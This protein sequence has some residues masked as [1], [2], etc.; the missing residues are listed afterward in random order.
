MRFVKNVCDMFSK[1]GIDDTLSAYKKKRLLVFNRLNS[2][3]L[4]MAI[5]W[6]VFT[7]SFKSHS[8]I[9]VVLN[10]L[11]CLISIVT[12]F[13]M[14][15]KKYKFAIYTNTILIPLALSLASIKVQEVSVLLYLIIYSILP[16]FYHSKF[17][18]IVAHYVYVI[19]LYGFALYFFQT[20]D[21][22]RYI[23]FSPLMQVAE[24]L[25]LFA[26]LYIVKMQVMAYEK[27]LKQN[28][29]SLDFKNKELTQMLI[30]KDQIFTVI[31][32]DIIV[33]LV[34]LKNMSEDIINEGYSAEELKAVFPMILDEINKTHNLFTNL[35]G[36]SKAQQ[37]GRGNITTDFAI[38]HV[39]DKVLE[40]IYYQAQKKNVN[41]VND[42]DETFMVNANFDNL[43]VAIR[44]LVVNAIKFT[45]EAGVIS[46]TTSMHENDV[47]LNI[48]DTGIGIDKDTVEKIFGTE[49]YSSKGTAAETG[50]GFG[51][52]ISSELLKQNA[53]SVFCQSSEKGVGS[54]FVIKL[55]VGKNKNLVALESA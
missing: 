36:W 8:P 52:K 17:Y 46:L 26:T 33:P 27:L 41:I 54:T 15:T 1:I 38:A 42:V 6:F 53:G 22:V 5:C 40:Q 30:L 28:K 29:E 48:S 43:S 49:L 7:T 20:H 11:P 45:P 12:Y 19:L 39:V 47:Q 18:K 44:N 16:F 51:L 32:H 10:F 50:N 34:G 25:F 2:F 21:Y 9:Y 14:Y 13:L 23:F 3:G 24:L 55:P 4:L 35:L 37:E 31:S